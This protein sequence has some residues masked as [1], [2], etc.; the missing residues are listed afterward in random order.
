MIQNL[1]FTLEKIEVKIDQYLL[2][3]ILFSLDS[4]I[5]DCF[6]E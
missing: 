2:K 5:L 3:I 1:F 6:E 4:V